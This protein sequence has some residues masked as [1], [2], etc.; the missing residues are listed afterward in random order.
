MFADLRCKI[1]HSSL[2]LLSIPLILSCFTHLWN[3]IGFLEPDHDESVYV[4]RAMHLL[5]GLGPQESISFYDHPYFGQLFLACI[6]KIIGYPEPLLHP[7]ANGDVHSIE[8]LWLVPRVIMG[9][10]AVA[11]TFLIYKIA[12][13]RYNR[14]VGFVASVLFAVMPITL[15]TTWIL[16]DSIQLPF[17][18]SSIIFALY[19]RHITKKDSTKNHAVNTRAILIVLLSGIFLGLSI[20]TKIPAFTMIP[21]VAYLVFKNSNKSFRL[22]GLWFIPVILIPAIWPAYALSHGQFG[23]WIN[24]VLYQALGKFPRPLFEA[25]R[26]IFYMDSLLLSLG[27]AGLLFAAIKLDFFPLLWAIPFLIFLYAIGFVSDFH[28]IPLVPILCI[29]AARLI[30]DLSNKIRYKKVQGIFPLVIV[31]VV[32]IFGLINTAIVITLNSTQPYFEA[33]AFL[34]KYLFQHKDNRITVIADPFYL[35]VPQYVFHL[36]NDYQ[37]YYDHTPIK[38]D[39]VLLIVD[40]N[41]KR[42]MLDKEAGRY[43]T[44]IYNLFGTNKMTTIDGVVITLGNLS[45]EHEQNLIDK[46]YVWKPTDDA[47]IFHPVNN[48][49]TVLVKTNST[50]KIYNR[51]IL[52]TKLNSTQ[53][54]PLLLSLDY[55]SDSLQGKAI[56]Y[57]EISNSSKVSGANAAKNNVLWAT[58]L[59]NTLGKKVNESFVL[60]SALSN[61]QIEFKFYIITYKPGMYALVVNKA[62]IT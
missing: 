24:G 8:M 31:A 9:I 28:L 21:L 38:G 3:P 4:R 32:G 34:S 22:L 62:N 58:T 7:V 41:F 33:S 39:K 35:W 13:Y 2:L 50:D 6:F 46:N 60:P 10:L 23:D 49:L 25:I 45:R 15:I 54:R 19:Y 53:N 42:I 43:L 5:S 1:F 36:D 37:T 12:E 57:A 56:F 44:N 27:A 51:A 29:A 20:F 59:K 30:V 47:K 11:D 40:P 17:L 55:S 26:G 18:L 14:K 48:G 16:L 61:K 52:Q